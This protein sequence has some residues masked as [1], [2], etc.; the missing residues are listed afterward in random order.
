MLALAVL[1]VFTFAVIAPVSANLTPQEPQKVEKR[2]VEK[3]DIKADDATLQKADGCPKKAEGC[4]KKAED[5]CCDKNHGDKKV[6]KKAV[7]KKKAVEKK[8]TDKQ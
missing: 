7:D 5:K 8:K 4:D 3:S 1:F 6:E 2:A